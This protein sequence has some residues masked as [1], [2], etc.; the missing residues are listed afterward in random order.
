M[1]PELQQ[2]VPSAVCLTCDGCCRFKEAES[3]WRPRLVQEEIKLAARQGLAER[4]FT[5]VLSA[6]GRIRT[7]CSHGEH[8]CSFFNPSDHTC[9][10]YQARPFECRLY[11]FILN[12]MNQ[13]IVV[14]V[15]LHCPYIQAAE[16]SPQFQEYAAYLKEYFSHRDVREFLKRNPTLIS[17]YSA[18]QNELRELFVISLS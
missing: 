4:I 12:K 2:F 13:Q 5:P 3:L 16:A 10:I 1:L 17:D 18:Y 8:L 11:P 14:C 15:H 7:H 6:D 9:R